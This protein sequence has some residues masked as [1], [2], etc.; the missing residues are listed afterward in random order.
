MIFRCTHRLLL[1]ACTLLCGLA[2]TPRARA[3]FLVNVNTSSLSPGTQGF[4]DMEFNPGPGS[5]AATATITHFSTDATFLSSLNGTLAGTDNGGSGT[6]PNTLT[7]NN[8]TQFNDVY[9]PVTYGSYIRFDVAF[10][11]P[12]GSLDNAGSFG[13]VLSGTVRQRFR[14]AALDHRSQRHGGYD[15]PQFRRQ[16]HAAYI[17]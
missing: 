15:Q 2:L 7:I 5:P 10:S 14:H 17:P 4:I 6:L 11:S 3:D 9:Q 1:L 16:R 8:T 12:S 13:L